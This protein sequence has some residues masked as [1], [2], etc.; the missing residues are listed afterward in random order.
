[1]A[2]ALRG[3]DAPDTART[4]SLRTR[5]GSDAV[6]RATA[7]AAGSILLALGARRRTM[8]GL[9]LAG[10][11]GVMLVRGA[12]GESPLA[13]VLGRPAS[14]TGLD[15]RESFLIQRSPEELYREWRDLERL[16]RILTHLQSVEVLD[17]RRTRWVVEAPRVA[18]GQVE[19]EAEIVDDQAGRAIAWRSLPG[20]S[21]DNVGEIR[22]EPAP[23][24]RGTYVRVAI[25]YRP[26][27]GRLGDWVAKL[28]GV[29]ARHQLREDLRAFKR[30]ME[31]G[32]LPTVEGQPV[33][34]CGGLGRLLQDG[35]TS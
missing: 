22:F 27:A 21:V 16:P 3:R 12:T 20:S 17:E 28:S 23:G 10:V 9:L 30:R 29:G 6:E 26:P 4:A 32:E 24:D 35:R 7:L 34:S 25:A 13:R 31:V 19:W 15:L 18:G 5:N 11:G 14:D 2:L 8:P 1:M 33:G